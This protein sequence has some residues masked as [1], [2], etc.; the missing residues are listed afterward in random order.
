MDENGEVRV[1]MEGS[2]AACCVGCQTNFHVPIEKA[3]KENVPGVTK[4]IVLWG[5]GPKEPLPLQGNYGAG[6]M[7]SPGHP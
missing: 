6:D 2:C 7:S 4:V 5:N 1:K 3:L